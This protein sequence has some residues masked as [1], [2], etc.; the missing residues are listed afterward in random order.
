[1]IV[2][3][4]FLR[5]GSLISRSIGCFRLFDVCFSGIFKSSLIV[6]LLRFLSHRI[7]QAPS[8]PLQVR[9]LPKGPSLEEIERQFTASRTKTDQP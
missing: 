6:L 8:G 3:S 5:Y 7:L 2:V 4:V 9:G 1:M